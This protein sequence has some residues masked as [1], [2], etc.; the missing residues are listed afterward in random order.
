MT[1]NIGDLREKYLAGGPG[2]YT[3][4]TAGYG[5]TWTKQAGTTNDT[6]YII[7]G[8]GTSFT[9][10]NGGAT[11]GSGSIQNT[12]N[13]IR[14]HATGT[15]PTIQFGNGTATLD[16][17]TASASFNNSGGTWGVV[18]LKGKITALSPISIGDSVSVTSMADIAADGRGGFA[19]THSS[20]GTLTI[21][22]GT[23]VTVYGT[24][25]YNE[26]TGT[27]IINDG[28]VSATSGYMG[29][30]CA[31]HNE[32]GMVIITGGTVS[33]TSGIAV[34][35]RGTS[36]TVSITGGTVSATSGIAVLNGSTS[37]GK[38][39]VSGT[40][41]VTSANTNSEEGTITLWGSG[42]A[43]LEI[44]GGMVENTSTTS[45]NAIRSD[46]A[47]A[48]II[49]GGTVSKA[50]SGNYAVYKS[51]SGEVTIGPGATIVGN[52]NF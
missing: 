42:Y 27:V 51:G 3:R 9:A 48:V 43:R 29:S 7:T 1:S 18:T 33:A 12:I 28:T 24:A 20:T 16:I 52:K 2:T 38:I 15:N 49:S 39:T 30:G 21:S 36:A 31:V 47:G 40:A 44:T 19:I 37:T 34:S 5:G 14:T 11:I 25:V 46:S 50:G 23:V 32:R 22:G 45:G 10:T 13:A 41:K 8:S 17:G 35:N 6:T 26:T 4:A